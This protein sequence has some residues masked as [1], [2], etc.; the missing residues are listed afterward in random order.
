MQIDPFA[1]NRTKQPFQPGKQFSFT[2]TPSNNFLFEEKKQQQCYRE[3]VHV[4]SISMYLFT[5]SF[6]VT[7]SF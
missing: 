1:N 4:K 6:P 7:M 2:A 3:V 5:Q